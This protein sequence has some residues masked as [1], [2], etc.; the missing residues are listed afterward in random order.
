M[1]DDKRLGLALL[2]MRLS[3]FL[4]MLMWTLDKFLRPAHAAGVFEHFYT[5]G[6]L[7][8]TVFYLLG[9]LELLLLLVFVAGL[10]QRFSYG[11]VLVLHAVSTLSA[12]RQYLHPQE[13]MNLLFFAAWPMLAAC[14]ALYLL[15]GHDRYALGSRTAPGTLR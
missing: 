4:V 10:A 6:G 11:V 2:L 12:W 13:G 15:R 1:T 8:S 9:A 14:L 5:M 3:V 7:G